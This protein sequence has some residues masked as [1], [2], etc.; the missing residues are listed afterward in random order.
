LQKLGIEADIILF[1]P[2]DEDHWGFDRMPA[3]ADDAYL[4]YV[5]SRLAAFRNVWWSLANEWD[6]MKKKTEADF[7]R[8]GEIVFREDLYHHLLSI[9]NGSKFFNHTLPWITHASI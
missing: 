2:Y 5:V 3:S 1:H 9:H 6:F 8:F 7:E 4:R